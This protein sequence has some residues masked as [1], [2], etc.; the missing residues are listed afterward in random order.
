MTELHDAIR[1]ALTGIMNGLDQV[2][3]YDHVPQQAGFPYITAGEEIL[4][5]WDD[6]TN[7]G[8]NAVF[9]IHVWSRYRGRYEVKTI[10]QAIYD[11]LHRADY[12]VTGYNQVNTVL[13]NM[14]TLL[15]PDGETRH[16]VQ[17]FRV[18]LQKE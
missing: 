5:P 17:S 2:P 11:R 3:V 4:T 9:T 7:T 10:Q 14:E 16:G 1:A 6:D 12:S 18:L 13:E 8:F 15:D